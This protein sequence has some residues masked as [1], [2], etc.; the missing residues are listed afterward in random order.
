MTHNLPDNPMLDFLLVL[1]FFK[2]LPFKRS[3]ILPMSNKESLSKPTFENEFGRGTRSVCY[4]KEDRIY[5][6][7]S[8]FKN[9][10][11]ADITAHIFQGEY[12]TI[13]GYIDKFIVP[14]IFTTSHIGKTS[15][16]IL[17]Q[18]FISGVSLSKALEMAKKENRKKD[19]ILDFLYKTKKMYE[20]TKQIP[21]IFGRP[22]VIGW[23]RV[24]HTPNVIVET[25][26]NLLTPRLID[27]SYTRISKLPLIGSMHNKLLAQSIDNTI[28]NII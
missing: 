4:K 28:R 10:D 13:V 15:S 1:T 6:V 22:H 16:V 24:L 3:K 18:P 12:E 20:E 23:Y 14:T 17:E 2:Q 19:E 27:I 11:E 26:N 9:K 8:G 25:D 7:I 5:K 21:D